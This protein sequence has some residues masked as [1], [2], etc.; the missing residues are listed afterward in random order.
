MAF[1]LLLLFIFVHVVAGNGSVLLSGLKGSPLIRPSFCHT[2][3][4]SLRPSLL[5]LGSVVGDILIK[6]NKDNEYGSDIPTPDMDFSIKVAPETFVENSNHILELDP[7]EFHP[8]PLI[9]Q[10]ADLELPIASPPIEDDTQ[11]DE[12]HQ[13]LYLRHSMLRS[14]DTL[15]KGGFGS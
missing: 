11:I 15:V 5:I 10:L 4:R 13:V 2:P 7:T 14:S 9:P 12:E 3:Q 8:P 1:P 6:E